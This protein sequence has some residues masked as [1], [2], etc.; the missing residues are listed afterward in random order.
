MNV[1]IVVGMFSGRRELRQKKQPDTRRILMS[2]DRRWRTWRM[3][4]LE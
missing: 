1:F 4:G 3:P 2:S